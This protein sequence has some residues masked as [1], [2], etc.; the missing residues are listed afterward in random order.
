MDKWLASAKKSKLNSECCETISDDDAEVNE[1]KSN[2][3]SNEPND[4][5][6]FPE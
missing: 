6:V 3:S 1:E 2:F 5:T 4:E